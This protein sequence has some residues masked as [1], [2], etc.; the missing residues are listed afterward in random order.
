MYKKYI[1]LYLYDTHM[2]EFRY[3]NITKVIL[4][5]WPVRSPNL[6]SSKFF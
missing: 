6:T 2:T 5:E 4:I 1:L 3:F